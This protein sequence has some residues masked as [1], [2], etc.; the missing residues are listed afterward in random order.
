MGGAFLR[1]CAPWVHCHG[2]LWQRGAHKARAEPSSAPVRHGCIAT[3]A[4]GREVQ[5]LQ[6]HLPHADL[7]HTVSG[8]D[9]TWLRGVGKKKK[10][11]KKKRK[12][13]KKKKKKKEKKKKKK[14]KKR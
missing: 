9:L 13:K 11:K 14:K 7:P 12:K 8:W 4:S 6:E 10:K 2:R 3:G 5:I 1:A